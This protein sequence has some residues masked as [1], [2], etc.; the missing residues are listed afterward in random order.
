MS[1]I[2][3]LEERRPQLPGDPRRR[4][5]GIAEWAAGAGIVIMLVL[6]ALWMVGTS[7]VE[8]ATARNDQ[9]F[10]LLNRQPPA[11][12]LLMLD[13]TDTLA[14][15][16]GK[17]FDN[18]RAVLLDELPRNGRLTVVPFGGDL[19]QSL[20]AKFSAC[21][22]GRRED[23][24]G[25]RESA[26]D[27]QWN[28]DENFRKPLDK[29]A[30]ELLDEHTS[31]SSPIAEQIERAVGDPAIVWRG[32]KRVLIVMSDGLQNTKDSRIYRG[33]PIALPEPPENLLSGVHVRYIELANAKHSALQ[34]KEVREAWRRWFVAAGAAE[35]EMDARGYAAGQSDH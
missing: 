10:C 34:T 9:T 33:A 23:V 6:M 21:S 11:A 29:I 18:L 26:D 8:E 30:Q 25:W 3:H 2:V 16:S 20:V 15:D 7:R 14:R 27:A 22:P 4:K 28:Y 19:G 35:V 17:R 12:Y 5:P 31:P 1:R 32:D 13:L 24:D